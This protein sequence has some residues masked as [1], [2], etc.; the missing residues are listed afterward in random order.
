[1]ACYRMNF[2]LYS[3]FTQNKQQFL[4]FTDLRNWFLVNEVESVYCAVRT[5]DFLNPLAPE[6][7]FNFSTPCI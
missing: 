2:T 7:F 3:T 6:L 1:M 5:E 4:L